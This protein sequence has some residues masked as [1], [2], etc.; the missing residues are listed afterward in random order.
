MAL[1]LGSLRQPAVDDISA[2]RSDVDAK[3]GDFSR[4]TGESALDDASASASFSVIW[5]SCAQ[6]SRQKRKP[7][8]PS[9]K[10]LRKKYV[11]TKRNRGRKPVRAARAF[12]QRRRRCGS[13]LN[14]SKT[15]SGSRRSR[16]INS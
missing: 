5:I 15:C 9:R 13:R 10:A 2:G 7:A 4:E 11:Y 3:L 1:D 14:A 16:R 6:R 8:R 12:R